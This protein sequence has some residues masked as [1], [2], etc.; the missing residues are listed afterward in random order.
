M[1]ELYPI[2]H[3]YHLFSPLISQWTQVTPISWLLQ[4]APLWTMGCMLSFFI[5][6][7]TNGYV[8]KSGLAGSYGN[9]I[10]PFLRKLHTLFHSGGTDLHS[11]QFVVFLMTT[12][13]T[14]VRIT[15]S[16][17]PTVVW[18]CISLINDADHLSPCLLAICISSSE[19]CLFRSFAHFLKVG[20]SF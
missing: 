14:D 3:T 15:V 9:S 10:V 6:V 11:D 1:A 13:L 17:Y 12:T 18:I 2:V 8:L 16:F 7:F 19:N 5:S 20:L 4:K